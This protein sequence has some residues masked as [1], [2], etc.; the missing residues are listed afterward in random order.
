MARKKASR[1]QRNARF[2]WL[3]Q[4]YDFGQKGVWDFSEQNARVVE[5]SR[6]LVVPSPNWRSTRLSK[7]PEGFDVRGYDHPRKDVR[8]FFMRSR[9][10][11]YAGSDADADIDR[12][13]KTAIPAINASLSP[14]E[15]GKLH[16][17]YEYPDLS[18]KNP[19]IGGMTDFWV[20]RAGI[21]Y[22]HVS[23]GKRSLGSDHI[24]IHETVHVARQSNRTGN[25]RDVEEAKTELETVAR[26][27]YKA[28]MGM[29]KT[30]G[31]Y[32][33]LKEDPWKAAQHDRLLLTGGLQVNLA[34][35]S[36]RRRVDEVFHKTKL[37]KLRI[38]DRVGPVRGKAKGFRMSPED[39]DRY[40]EVLL[41]DGRRVQV[42]LSM[43]G[44]A[45]YREIGQMLRERY[46]G[47]VMVYEFRDGY[48]IPI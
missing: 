16:A 37:S 10:P 33:F 9:T 30:L 19:K 34:G 4:L 12:F 48:R 40:F 21:P 44:S 35:P 26:M 20:S 18:I 28:F 8:P 31:Y 27:P 45:T 15:Q 42:H 2:N 32:I 14:G 7:L 5:P 3:E 38:H 46:A 39:V 41:G 25:D 1:S 43:V 22:S 13:G 17:Y 36:A 23:I 47:A 6:A 11:V 24:L 29:Q